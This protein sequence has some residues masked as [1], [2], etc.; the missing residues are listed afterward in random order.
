MKQRIMGINYDY[1]SSTIFQVGEIPSRKTKPMNNMKVNSS[2][3][4]LIG[5]LCYRQCSGYSW[6]MMVIY[7]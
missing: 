5:N 1:C 7:I 2:K 3:Y 4:Y 6:L